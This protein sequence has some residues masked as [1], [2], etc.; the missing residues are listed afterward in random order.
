MIRVALQMLSPHGRTTV[1]AWMPRGHD[2][3]EA[4][5]KRVRKEYR[6]LPTL[7]LTFAQACRLWQL[8]PCECKTVLD[9]LIAE[10]VLKRT[11]D[12]LFVTDA[13]QLTRIA[14]GDFGV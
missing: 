13:R 7:N 12:G 3:A 5:L 10:G 8:E 6:E 9:R 2:T 1:I 4:L 11:A 14:W